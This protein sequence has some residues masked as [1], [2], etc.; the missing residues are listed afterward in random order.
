MATL[1]TLKRKIKTAKNVSKT[2]KA[3]QMISASKLKKAEEGAV[4]SKP[5]VSKLELLS[6]SISQKLDRTEWDDYMVSPNINSKLILIISPDKGLCGGLVTNL[7]REVLRQNQ[8]GKIYYL[9][10]GKK[11]ESIAASL[12]KEIIASFHFGNSLPAFEFVYP[13]ANII[14][15]Y[16]LDRK[17][18]RV[19]IISTKFVNVFT[20]APQMT[21]LLPITLNLEQKQNGVTIF[22]PEV[23]N[24]LSDI[25]RHY[26]EMMIYQ[27]LLEAY[28]SEQASRMIAMRNATDNAL[29]IIDALQLEYNKTRQEKITNEL[30]DIGGGSQQNYA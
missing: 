25:L 10:I 23:N 11:A 1:L 18:S 30:L 12:N 2:T 4:S 13:V 7:M 5:Y 24:L 20:Q 17:V 9:T 8:G 3:M 27:S 29:D 6:K 28:A 21:D 15:E 16:F 19:Q 26:L 22:E 14:N